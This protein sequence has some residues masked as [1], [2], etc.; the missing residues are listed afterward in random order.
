MNDGNSSVRETWQQPY[1]VEWIQLLLDSYRHWLAKELMARDGT[2]C[3]Q[4]RRVFEWPSIIV[5]H[6]L[7][8][9]PILNY[10]NCA[11]LTLWEMDWTQ[12]TNTPSRL[13]A[14][15]INQAERA[16]MLRRAESQGYIDDYRG[17]RISKTGNRFLVE[18][19]TVWNVVN[20]QGVKQGQAA[21]FSTW[22]YLDIT[23]CSRKRP[24]ED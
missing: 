5:S 18:N 19:A 23:G 3:D 7:Q 10:G 2:F 1:V 11:A 16:E 9:D 14:E 13:T 4:A 12:L 6:G 21:T 20:A 17:V 15:P 8:D 24:I 22:S